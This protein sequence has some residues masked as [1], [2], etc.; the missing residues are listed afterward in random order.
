MSDCHA[1][2]PFAEQE[3]AFIAPVPHH[4]KRWF[5]SLLTVLL[6]IS[7]VGQASFAARMPCGNSLHHA[8]ADSHHATTANDADQVRCHGKSAAKDCSDV[9]KRLCGSVAFAAESAVEPV[10][11]G[12]PHRLVPLAA[13]TPLSRAITPDTPPPIA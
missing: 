10:A 4:M 3:P 1:L 13:D 5:T 8:A 2:V 7:A 6:L 9:C 11:I 12:A